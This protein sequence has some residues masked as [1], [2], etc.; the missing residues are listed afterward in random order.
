MICPNRFPEAAGCHTGFDPKHA[1]WVPADGRS[2]EGSRYASL[3][4][5]QTPDLRGMFLR[6]LNRSEEDKLRT[7][8]KEDPNGKERIAGHAQDDEFRSHT[9]V[10]GSWVRAD[11]Q[12]C[13]AASGHWAGQSMEDA[14]RSAGGSETRPRNVAV[15]YYIRI[16]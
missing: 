15:Y 11:Q 3:V 14:T 9:H 13:L 5:P 16:N 2:V 4:S 10:T 1:P 6:G 8:G 7:D 12:A